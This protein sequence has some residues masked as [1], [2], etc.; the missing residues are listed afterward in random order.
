MKYAIYI[1][2]VMLL[3]VGVSAGTSIEHP[4][5][6]D[7]QS[8]GNHCYDYYGVDNGFGI[9]ATLGGYYGGEPYENFCL[10]WE[11]G[12]AAQARSAFV[13]LTFD[14]GAE[15]IVIRHLDGQSN[16]DSFDV[17]VNG[18]KIGHYTDSLDSTEKWVVSE[19]PVNGIIG[20][21]QQVELVATDAA[22]SSCDLWGQIAVDYINVEPNNTVPEFGLIAG[23]VALVGL[24]AGVVILRKR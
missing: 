3:A 24:V 20:D 6:I 22:W 12:C 21:D 11:P 18:N 2:M 9:P 5:S 19:F 7:L 13:Y 23:L 1:L 10:V 14:G 15:K 17:K 16:L 4:R 8:N